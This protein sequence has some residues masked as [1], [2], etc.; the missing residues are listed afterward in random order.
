MN[1]VEKAVDLLVNQ[2]LSLSEGELAVRLDTSGSAVRKVIS[3]VRR[4]GYAVYLNGGKKDS[5]GR[6]GA[7]RYRVGTPT[8]KM[9]A[10]FYN[11][12]GHG[13]AFHSK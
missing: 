4:K 5:R 10:S 11:I 2:G 6:T 13:E 9:I 1:N 8:R 12:F 7:S 3:R